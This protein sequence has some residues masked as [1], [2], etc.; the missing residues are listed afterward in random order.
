MLYDSTDVPFKSRSPTPLKPQVPNGTALQVSQRKSPTS[1]ISKNVISPSTSHRIS[2]IHSHNLNSKIEAQISARPHSELHF[3]STREP[4]L[5]P[6]PNACI[7]I[8]KPPSIEQNLGSNMAVIIPH[9]SDI[10]KTEEYVVW[11]DAA[12][13]RAIVSGKKR[14]RLEAFDDDDFPVGGSDQREKADAAFRSLQGYMQE[15]FEAE[16]QIGSNLSTTNE[17]F[18]LTIDDIPTLTSAVHSKVEPLL[19]KIISFGKFSQIPIDDLI[20]LQRLSE[21]SLKAAET[22]DVKIEENWEENDVDIWLQSVSIAES[23]LKSARTL[24][25]LMTA[26]REEKQLYSEEIIQASLNTFKNA[27]DSYVIPIVELRPFGPTAKLFKLLSTQ[28]KPLITTL[29]LCRRLLSLIKDLVASIELSETVINTLEFTV[30]QLIFVEN[31]HSEKESV[32]GVQKF[33]S[34]RVV[35]MDALA[36]IFSSYP[37]QRRGIFDEILTSLEKLPVTKQSARQFKLIEGGSIQLVSALIMR[38]IQT[39]ASK[40]D[41]AKEKRRVKNLDVLNGN[42][43]D[44]D[45]DL[46]LEGPNEMATLYSTSLVVDTERQAIKQHDTAVQELKDV[47]LPLMDV[48]KTSASYVVGFIV[49]RA[50]KSTKTGDQPYRNLLDLFVQDF[51]TCLNSADWPAA[52]L[53]LRVFLVAMVKLAEGEKTAAPAKNMALDVLAEMGAAISQLNSHLQRPVGTLEGADADTELS[54]HLLRLAESSSEGKLRA[55]DLI[56]WNGP[57]R[58]TIEFLE[59]ED[60]RTDDHA[61]QSAIGYHVAEWGSQICD[62]FENINDNYSDHGQIEE[63]FGRLAYRLRK[64]ITDKDWLSTEYTLKSLGRGYARLAYNLTLMN[65]KFCNSFERIFKII[66]DCMRSEQ[67]T[68]RSKSLKSV[69]QVLETDPSILDRFRGVMRLIMDCSSDSSV[70]VR[71][72]ALG[73]I[74]KCIG[75]RPVLEEELMAG[76]LQRVSDTGIGVRKRAIKLLKDIYLRNE[77]KDIRSAIAD[78]LLHRVTDLDE[79]IQELARQ[80]IEEVWMQPFYLPVSVTEDLSVPYRL[81]IA[82]HVS[83]MVKTIQRRNE[84]SVVLDKVLQSMLSNESRHSAANFRVCKTLVAAMFDTIIDNSGS[85]VDEA[86]DALQ[87]L[88]IFAKANAKLFTADQIQLLPPYIADLQKEDDLAKFRSVVVIFRHVFP[89]LSKVHSRFLE[90]VRITLLQA[91]SRMNRTLL[92]DV[93]ACLWIISTVDEN[94]ENLTKVACSSLKRCATFSKSN[95]LLDPKIKANNTRILTKLLMISGM[96]GKHWDLD[97]HPTEFKEKFPEWKGNSVSKLMVDTFVPFAAPHHPLEVRKAA[98]DAIGMVCQSRPK[99]YSSASIYTTFQF[100]FEERIPVLEAMIMRSFR[101]F[102]LMEEKR[103]DPGTTNTTV[104]VTDTPATLGVMGGSQNDGVAADIAQKFLKDIARIALAT[105]DDHAYLATEILTSINRQ[106]MNHPKE[107]GPALVALETSQNA[108][109][110]DLAFREHRALHEKY[111]TILEK[112]YMRAVQFAYTYQRDIVKDTH[113]AKVNPYTPKL[114]LLMEVLKISKVKS[115]KRFFETLCARMDFD[116]VKLDMSQVPPVHVDFSRFIVENIAFFEYQSV[117]EILVAITA[118]EKIVTGTGSAVAHAIETEIFQVRI[119]NISQQMAIDGEVFASNC[120]RAVSPTRLRQLT[121]AAM[122][123]CS[124]WETRT[125]LRRAYGL[126][127]GKRENKSKVSAKDLNKVPV[128]VPGATGDKF[129]DEINK[130]MSSLSSLEA[131]MDQCKTFV[132]LLTVDKDFKIAAEGEDDITRPRNTTPSDEGESTSG[133]PSGS[134]KGGKRKAPSTP[135]K[136]RKHVST[137]GSGLR[138][139]QKKMKRGSVDGDEDGNEDWEGD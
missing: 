117:D 130:I 34:L 72:S 139:R 101:D 64:M 69:N 22:I 43:N 5:E 60:H 59:V 116:P 19:S 109:I 121:A 76:I 48:A 102:L 120:E 91:M 71:D 18:I 127:N 95:A 92:D 122:I 46:G 31:G 35:A 28:K 16:C 94:F 6:Q 89:Q 9:A 88:M 98:L 112:E 36:Q 54:R 12:E 8:T 82:D 23:G 14:K 119:D 7:Q 79:G 61:L 97:N 41:D 20:R 81:A 42:S 11:E 17:F 21:G 114:Y 24:L 87:L 75:L 4:Q 93:V 53:L 74:G 99:N 67:A 80:T 105:Q 55:E 66:L 30:S 37:S 135:S 86:R 68:V 124:I 103:S 25:R 129:W 83:M 73:L 78:A 107:C 58:A 51:I 33:D 13:G 70:Q 136:R 65:S 27:M 100:V 108:S 110:A 38:L 137:P 134:G 50:M 128:K 39:S 115:R 62:S 3:L 111:E 125:F 85:G 44:H 45:V 57:Y 10:I 32:L 1:A 131:M 26:G 56:A 138:G 132:E 29:F 2:N 133:P 47:V 96:C 104:G 77:K 126:M 118:M 49:D 106:G 84:V 15:I 52:E 113:G 123:L 90:N 63:E 40:S